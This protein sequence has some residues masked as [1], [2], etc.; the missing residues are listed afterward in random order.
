MSGMGK[1]VMRKIGDREVVCRE[2]TVAA[3]R[4]LLAR[5]TPGDL[6]SA[7]LF[8]DV[9]LDDL[10][11]LTSLTREEVDAALPSELETVVEGCKEANPHFFA[12]L[13]RLT[14]AQQQA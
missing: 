14:K 3:V 13:G 8:E 1:A 5:T 11:V 7:A 10:P 6:V 12:M 9:A 2:L 4:Q